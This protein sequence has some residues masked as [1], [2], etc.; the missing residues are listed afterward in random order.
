[1]AVYGSGTPTSALVVRDVPV[2]LATFARMLLGAVALWGC[3]LVARTLSP[4]QRAARVLP[5]GRAEWTSLLGVVV[6]GMVLFSV[7]MLEGMDRAPGSLAGVIM[8]LTRP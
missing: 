8:G 2:Y 1:M 6:G 5:Q 7:F 3:L 4:K